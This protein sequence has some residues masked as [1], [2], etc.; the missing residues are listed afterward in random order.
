[1]CLPSGEM[2]GKRAKRM[3][4]CARAAVAK[5][6]AITTV[7]IEVRV[8]IIGGKSS[9]WGQSRLA[10]PVGRGTSASTQREDEHDSHNPHSRYSF[11]YFTGIEAGNQRPS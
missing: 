5:S 7:K 10:V 1:M 11:A 3:G 2:S 4:S 9:E 6:R 8:R